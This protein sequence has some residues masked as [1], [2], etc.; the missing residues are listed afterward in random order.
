MDQVTQIPSPLDSGREA[1]PAELSDVCPGL[2]IWAGFD[3][4]GLEE[5]NRGSKSG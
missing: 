1:G 3:P 4:V 2:V 5:M